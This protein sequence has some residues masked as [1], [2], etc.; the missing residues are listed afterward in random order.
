MRKRILPF[1]KNNSGGMYVDVILGFMIIIIITTVMV[2]LF[3]SFALAQELNQTARIV[4]RVVEV[5]GRVGDEVN[6]VLYDSDNMAPDSVEWK[7]DYYN[8]EAHTIQ[9]KDTFTVILTKQVPITIVQPTF[10]PPIQIII[11]LK[12]DASGVS[13]VYWK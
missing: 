10:G 4:S 7:V 8:E 11:T 12:A 5:T 13:E 1:F 6:E 3:P 2:T 9:L